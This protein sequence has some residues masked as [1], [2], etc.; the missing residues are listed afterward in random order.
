MLKILRVAAVGVMLSAPVQAQDFD[1][2]LEAALA[3]DFVTALEVWQP[4]A[5]QGDSRAQTALGLLYEEGDGVLQDDVEAVRWYRLAAEQGSADALGNLGVMYQYGRGVPQDFAE[6]VRLYRMAAKQG[7]ARAQTNLGSMYNDGNGV[8]QD[9]VTAH[10]W[11]N[12]SASNG[13][14]VG[15][16][17]RDLV[18]GLMTPDAMFEAQRRARACVESDYQDCD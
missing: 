8:V 18:V 4:L 14:E 2:G 15:A 9:Y 7:N 11:F 16:L 3:D 12:V 1:V 17:R 10:M 13:S 6:A 5:A